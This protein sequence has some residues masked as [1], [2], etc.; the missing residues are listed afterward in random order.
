MPRKKTT[1]YKLNIYISSAITL[2][3]T[4]F[5]V[6]SYQYGN[7]IL[8]VNIEKSAIGLSTELISKVRDNVVTTQEI[9]SNLGHQVPIIVEKA[10]LEILFTGLLKRYPYLQ[11]IHVHLDSSAFP[12]QYLIYSAAKFDNEIRTIKS[13]N[14]DIE[15]ED[16]KNTFSELVEKEKYG[17]SEPY[18]CRAYDRVISSFIRPILIKNQNNETV[19]IGHFCIE[20]SL[21]YL[22]KVISNTKIGKR[23]YAFLISE[24]GTFIT[25]PDE[26]RILTQNIL[27]LSAKEIPSPPDSLQ[28]LLRRNITGSTIAYPSHLNYEKSWVYYTPLPENDWTIIIIRPHKE[29]YH[30]LYEMLSRLIV[31][32]L[33]GLGIIFFLIHLIVSRLMNPISQLIS[34]IHTFSHGIGMTKSKNEVVSLNKSLDQLQ[35]WVERNKLNEEQAKLQFKKFSIDLEQASEIQQS[36]IP[37]NFPPFPDKKEIDIFSIYKPALV[38][39][40]DLYD[41]FFV[42]DDHL[43]LAIGD[44]SGKG[45]PAALFMGVAHTLLQGRSFGRNA[46]QVASEINDELV[47]KNQ[48]QFF[49]T[50]FVGILNIKTGVLNYCNAAHTTSKI[51]RANGVI[52]ELSAAHGLPLGLYAGRPYHESFTKLE[53]NDCIILYTDGVTDAVNGYNTHFGEERFRNSLNG[54]RNLHPNEI[55]KSVEDSINQ[56]RK[57][58][59]LPDDL[60][61]VV[62]K[63]KPK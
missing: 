17:W 16:G 4:T 24:N 36:I 56:F 1:G 46:S 32:S 42:D 39:S 2:V 53:D 37:N 34:E 41:Y 26:S 22:N 5:I 47:E 28:N 20:L 9:A 50:M 27:N 8:K 14:N 61:M 18:Y 15:C 62:L 23:G 31:I 54:L 12:N 49:L 63:F 11:A 35:I 59:E 29:L 51:L 19:K 10:D 6:I 21:N 55:V 3:L 52:E 60:S 45:I 40:G 43:L 7:R 57:E 13:Y 38:I 44:V 48:N 33:L 30:D 25:H 58:T